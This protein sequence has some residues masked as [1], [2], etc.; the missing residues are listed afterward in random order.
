MTNKQARAMILMD[1]R[2]RIRSTESAL[3]I[4][5]GSTH[6]MV[7][8]ILGFHRVCAYWVTKELTEEHKHNCVDTSIHLLEH[9]LNEHNNFLNPIPLA[10]RIGYFIMKHKANVKSMQWKH[11]SS[12][13][14]N[15]QDSAT[16]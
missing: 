3:D 4:S 2:I 12:P 14:A 15:V 9:Y 5:E 8:D 11:T 1:R 13:D 7:H 10:M 6:S 16:S